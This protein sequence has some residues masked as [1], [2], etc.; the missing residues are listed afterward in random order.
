MLPHDELG[1]GR[2][3]VLLHAG[4]ADRTMWREHLEPFAQAGRRAIAPDM[5]G[6]GDADPAEHAGAPWAQLLRLL[7]ELGVERAAVVGNSFGG[8]VALRLALIAPERVSALVLVSAPAPGV[9]ASG[10]L[11]AVWEAE[12]AALERAD[13]ETAVRVVVEAWTLPDAPL[14]LRERVGAMQRRAFDLQHGAVPSAD[15]EDPL[16]DEPEALR[17]I[18]APTLL[19]AGADDMGDFREGAVRLARELPNARAQIVAG[20]GHLL[21]LEAPAPFR[22]LV[23]EFLA[24]HDA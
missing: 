2:P 12:E 1:S 21:P 24:E 9:A 15:P 22:V 23:L 18:E 7:D 20:A 14:A 3:L 17:A 19:L 8:A 13:I 10:E 6:F 5:P 16:D 4:V 11:L